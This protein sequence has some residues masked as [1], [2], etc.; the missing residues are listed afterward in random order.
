MVCF[1]PEVR[2]CFTVRGKLTGFRLSWW[3]KDVPALKED[4]TELRQSRVGR[5]ARLRGQVED[6]ALPELVN[7]AP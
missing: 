1:S 2:F 7:S 3:K 6:L 5:L 4:Y